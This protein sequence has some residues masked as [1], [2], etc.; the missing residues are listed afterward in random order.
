MSLLLTLSR[1]IS[2]RSAIYFIRF[3]LLLT[4]IIPISLRVNLDTAKFV[5]KYYIENDHELYGAKVRNSDINEELGRV[6]IL[7]TDKTG[8][9]TQ[10]DMSLAALFHMTLKYTINPKK[11]YC[12]TVNVLQTFQFSSTRKR[13]GVIVKDPV[14]QK[15]IYIVK[16]ADT[17][18]SSFSNEPNYWLQESLETLSRQGLRN[19]VYAYKELSPYY[20]ETMK[21]EFDDAI[22]Q[23]SN[24]GT[25]IDEIVDKY[26]D[27]DLKLIGATAV[28]D[29]LQLEVPQ[30]IECLIQAGI[31]VWML[32]GD[33][34][35][36]ALSIATSSSLKRRIDIF[37]EFTQATC[38]DLEF[39]VY[40]IYQLSRH[41]SKNCVI[42]VDSFVID[43][44]NRLYH[45]AKT[46]D[47]YRKI[48]SN[49][50]MVCYSKRAVIF[51]RCSPY[52]KKELVEI[53][54]FLLPKM[55]ICAIGD[56]GND[57]PMLQAAHCG[58]GIEGKE[59]R[60]AALISDVSVHTFKQLKPLLLYHGRLAQFSL[61]SEDASAA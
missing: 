22:M 24:R 15:I 19:L 41:R 35:E 31:K 39:F 5:Y 28:D 25:R 52:Q 46:Q 42:C 10:N 17:V 2:S 47:Y 7:L 44:I 1:P 38:Q 8:T 27:C 21:Q 18:I 9:L 20:Y 56:G 36:T 61:L 3:I 11:E 60:Q 34:L 26:L 29:K 40:R 54:K 23:M 14:S 37:F 32:T 53:I 16:G 4:C 13:M 30:T 51:T 57:V 6:D 49:F 43:L 45:L 59:G 48:L 33:K 58:I 12:T 50:I 55:R